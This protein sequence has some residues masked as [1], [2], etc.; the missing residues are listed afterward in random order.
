MFEMEN[1][2]TARV[3]LAA[4]GA[5][6]LGYPLHGD[7]TIRAVCTNHRDASHATTFLDEYTTTMERKNTRLCYGMN[8]TLITIS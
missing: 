2:C 5:L 4:D 8:I 3:V 6:I 7:F 1:A